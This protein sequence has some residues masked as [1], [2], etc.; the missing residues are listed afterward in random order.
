MVW[1]TIYK[2]SVGKKCLNLCN[3]AILVEI[4][5]RCETCSEN[6]KCSSRII[7]RSFISLDLLLRVE[8]NWLKEE[9]I[10][11]LTQTNWVLL[12]M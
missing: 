10:L 8:V 1:Y 9:D 11:L 2:I 5:V 3:K 12:V 7:D 6:F 4:L